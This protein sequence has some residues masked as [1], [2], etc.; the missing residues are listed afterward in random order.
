MLLSKQTLGSIPENKNL[1]IPAKNYFNLPEKVLQ[2]GTGVLLR[3]LPDYFIDKANKQGLFNGRVVLIKSTAAGSAD[4]FNKQDGLYTLCVK[5]IENDKLVEENSINASISRVLSASSEWEK[6]L[7]CAGDPNIEIVISNTTEVGLDLVRESIHESPPSSYPAK[8]LAIL[9]KRYKAFNGDKD[10]GMVI[11]PTELIPD[12]GKKLSAVLKELS[13][14]N[15]LESLFINWL[16]TSNHFCSSLVDRIVPGKL[17]ADKQK[18][19]EKEFGYEDGLMI[20]SESYRLWAIEASDK[21][22]REIV[23]FSKADEGVIIAPD[24]FIF[25]ELKLRLLNGAH[26]YSCGLAHLAGFRLVKDAMS[27]P[28]FSSYITGLMMQEIVPAITG[29]G[30][31]RE[32]AIDFSMKVLD[33]FRNPY[34]EH[35]WL[36]ITLQYSSKMKMRN[37]PTLL[38][39]YRQHQTVP[40]YMALGYAAHILFMRCKKNKDGKYEGVSNDSAYIINDDHAEIYSQ[41]CENLTTENFVH[42]T[43]ADQSLWGYDLSELPGFEKAVLENIQLLMREGVAAAINKTI[44]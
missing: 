26:T 9:Y 44:L 21:K 24:I 12:N 22:V 16:E 18:Q 14:Y 32:M 38:K 37:V 19:A 39:Y 25:R 20:M 33:R 31:T 17:P 29:N 2:F 10:K 27:D 11:I 35:A 15:N 28:Q 42:E 23:S 36:S 5:G 40:A 7:D 4:E 30:I 41:R 34:I 8:L 3:G 1:D 43:L 6:I 13:V